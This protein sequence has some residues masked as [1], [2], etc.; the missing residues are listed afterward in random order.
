M[1]TATIEVSRG[2]DSP[3][4]AI[5]DADCAE[6][7]RRFEWSLSDSGYAV[8]SVRFDGKTYVRRLHRIVAD[9]PDGVIVDHING[10]KLDC[11]A[12]NLRMVDAFGN[13]Q[14]RAMRARRVRGIRYKGVYSNSNCATYT[15][16]IRVNGKHIYL[17]SFKEQEDAAR[18]YDAAALEH[19]GEHSRL[20][21][22]PEEDEYGA[23]S[24]DPCAIQGPE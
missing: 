9:A 19:F 22:P 18:A 6:F 4:L 3:V 15:A 16:R 12:A 24:G 23:V 5:V 21:F 13:A 8:R 2:S 20:N 17:G 14:N 10:D 7:L 1:D 11:R